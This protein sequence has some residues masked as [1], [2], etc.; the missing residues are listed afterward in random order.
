MKITRSVYWIVAI[1]S[2]TG[3]VKAQY[4]SSYNPVI[5]AMPSLT[6]AP[7]A[8]AGGMGDI[9]TATMPDVYSQHWNA[10]KYPFTSSGSGI[11][12]AYTPWLSAI[13]DDV[14]LLY[15]AGYTKFGNDNANTISTSL[16]YFSLG[17]ISIFNTAGELS[18]VFS[19]HELAIDVAYSRKLTETFS[20]SVT[21]RYIRA[22]FSTGESGDVPGNAFAVDIAGYNESY[23]P[24]G[25]AEALLGVGFNLSNIGSK[26]SYDGGNNSMFLPA[27][28][29]IGTSLG[30]PIDT[31]N[32][33]TASFDLSKLMVPTFQPPLESEAPNEISSIAGIF[34]S[35]GDA[36]GGIKEELQEIAW[37]LGAEYMYDNRFSLRTGYFHENKNKGNRRYVAAGVGLKMKT[38]HVDIAYLITTMHANPLDKTLRISLGI[39]LEDVKNLMH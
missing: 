27:N 36:P 8:R 4:L 32:T 7:D 24:I 25:N 29:R 38:F 13:V 3:A 5:T 34:K 28:L 33:I 16:R 11:A 21:L 17:D 20:G 1:L 14:Y 18:N 9:G 19:P 39:N 22:D 6:I 35:F 26:I 15:I 2:F 12:F 10:A 23:L 31:K 30:F 37:S